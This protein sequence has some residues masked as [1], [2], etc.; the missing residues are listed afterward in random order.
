MV[1]LQLHQQLQISDDALHIHVGMAIL[2]LAALA[3]RRPPWDW[4]AVL[5]VAVIET[6]N[7]IYDMRSLANDPHYEGTAFDSAHDF[8]LT[9]L[10]PVTIA[11]TFPI[12]LRVLKRRGHL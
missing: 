10:W 8:V 5:V 1:K 9:M 12:F 7:E 3:L 6:V 11:V 4:Y 2:L